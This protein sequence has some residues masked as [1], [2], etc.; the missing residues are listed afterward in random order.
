M[1]LEIFGVG[2]G[3]GVDFDC[4]E[5]SSSWIERV[6]TLEDLIQDHVDDSKYLIVFDE[7]DEDYKDILN[8]EKHKEYTALL[9]SLFK[10]VQDIK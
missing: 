7:L 3:V 4:K 8:A 10:A 2:G 5:N 1:N 6:E 9:T